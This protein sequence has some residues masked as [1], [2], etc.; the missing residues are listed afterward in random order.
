M[1]TTKNISYT[2]TCDVC[3]KREASLPPG[4]LFAAHHMPAGWIEK[5]MYNGGTHYCSEVCQNVMWKEK[6]EAQNKIRQEKI[7]KKVTALAEVKLILADTF[8][9]FDHESLEIMHLRTVE[10]MIHFALWGE[11]SC[12]EACT[13]TSDY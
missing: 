5:D 12:N 13:H 8:D 11:N 10:D 9:E 1:R 7:T 6:E 2:Y 3:K 4:P